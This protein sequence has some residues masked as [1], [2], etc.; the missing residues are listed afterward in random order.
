[1]TIRPSCSGPLS[2]PTTPGLG[3][4][5]G[6]QHG[7]GGVGL[8]QPLHHAMGGP[9]AG[10]DDR[11][12]PAGADVRAQHREDAVDV[13]LMPARR[14][15]RPDVQLHRRLVGQLAQGP[16]RMTGPGRRGLHVVQFGEAR[17][18]QLLDV[19]GR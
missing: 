15:R 16:P 4:A 6:F 13:V 2:T 18:A 12:V 5:P 9:G 14:R 11:G 19:D 17:S 3:A 1:M 8:G 10:C 7:G